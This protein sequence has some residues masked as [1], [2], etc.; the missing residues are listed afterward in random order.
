MSNDYRLFSRD[1]L[2][3]F[4]AL[5]A[6]NLA[7]MVLI[8]TLCTSVVG[9]PSD[10]VFGRILPGVG[11]A[12]LAGLSF[13]A[14]Q[15]HRLAAKENRTDV[16]AL[17]YGISTPVL[18]VYLFAVILPVRIVT[19]NPVLAWQVGLAAAFI[20]G[21]IEASGSLLG[22]FLKRIT[23]RAGMLGTLAGIALVWIATVPMAEL[24]EHP[25]VGLVAMSVILIGLVAQTRL[26]WNLPA[27]LV[28]IVVG[29]VLALAMGQ[30]SITTKG[31][32]F[33]P[34]IPVLGDLYEG[35]RYVFLH[36]KIL[37][38]VLPME[39]YN[40]IETMNNVESAEAAGDSYDVAKC[41][42]ADG[43]GTIVG[44]LFGSAF[45]TTVYIGHPAYKR[46]GARAGYALGVGLVFFLGAVF[47]LIAFLH[48]VVPMAAVAPLLIFV[49]MAIYAQANNAVPKAHVPAVTLAL[50]PHVADL[51]YKQ[52]T[53]G[54]SSAALF[55]GKGLTLPKSVSE[56]LSDL[57]SIEPET[58][59]GLRDI[60]GIHA[61][62]H[63]TGLGLLSRGAIVTGLVW[64]AMAAFVIDRKHVHAAGFA[65]GGAFLTFLGFIHTPGIRLHFHPL[66]AGY[67]AMASLFLAMHFARPH[68]DETI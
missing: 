57:Q 18:F 3:G 11:M 8:A 12:L 22:P 52:V 59:H 39:I 17:P 15:A 1:D 35:L 6:D 56:R 34:P 38:I 43:A 48:N 65:L 40:F 5:F 49:S 41:Q 68:I 51:V 67:L 53:G 9:I 66:V 4:W 23:P 29:T 63:L 10:I 2:S 58:V 33:Y 47:G 20:G 21:I 30:M 26:P 25:I 13:Y 60:L 24:F 19:N 42:L 7:N 50:I 46:L 64:G 44:A 16:T 55:V 36:P 61:G 62:I 28:A 14:W 31:M 54:L 45:P 32:G 37:L 27:G